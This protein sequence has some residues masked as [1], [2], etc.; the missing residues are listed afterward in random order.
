MLFCFRKRGRTCLLE[1][2]VKKRK[3]CDDTHKNNS[4]KTTSYPNVTK[5]L[6]HEKSTILNVF[7]EIT[8]V[9]EKCNDEYHSDEING[10]AQLPDAAVLTSE[11]EE[12][13]EELYC[14][15]QTSEFVNDLDSSQCT[16]PDVLNSSE[17]MNKDKQ[18]KSKVNT[19][20]DN[21][22]HLG[23]FYHECQGEQ[24]LFLS[25]LPE[26]CIMLSGIG[27]VKCCLGSVTILGY[28]MRTAEKRAIFAPTCEAPIMVQGNK[29]TTPRT[30]GEKKFE[31][32]N[33]SQKIKKLKVKPTVVNQKFKNRLEKM[34]G[35]L[36]N[37]ETFHETKW[38]KLNINLVRLCDKHYFI[39]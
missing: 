20:T 32:F 11:R 22:G 34:C 30:L 8:E 12:S 21:L 1:S 27:Y 24:V 10:I 14:P 28:R 29:V 2:K 37:K 7:S 13:S 36:K 3:L 35:Y 38:S 18:L 33:I 19:F 25:M 16:E 23:H 15:N 4:K 17:K 31:C 5:D 9:D 6:I 39:P 26:H